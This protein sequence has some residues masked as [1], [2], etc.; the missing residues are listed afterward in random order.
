MTG[1]LRA[2]STGDGGAGGG[3]GGVGG[4]VV[5]RLGGHT[6][7]IR[8]KSLDLGD[9]QRTEARRRLLQTKRTASFRQNSATESADSIEIYIPEAQTRLWKKVSHSPPRLTSPLW[10][11]PILVFL[12]AQ[13]LIF[14]RSLLFILLP[15]FSISISSLTS[16]PSHTH[17]HLSCSLNRQWQPFQCLEILT[18]YWRRAH[19]RFSRQALFFLQRILWTFFVA[20]K[21]K[22]QSTFMTVV[23]RGSSS[24]SMLVL[25][26]LA[27]LHHW[28]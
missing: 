17:T 13:F 9:R 5:P 7:P 10:S 11:P 14:Y 25:V 6:L 8:E 28:K 1:S 3:G 20:T 23:S 22:T 2:D 24:S 15:P 27:L 16:S 21:S 18:F 26:H 12:W 4:L 19:P